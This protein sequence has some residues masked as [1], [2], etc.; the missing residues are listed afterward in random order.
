MTDKVEVIQEDREAAAAILIGLGLAS[1]RRIAN[2]RKG[3]W[4]DDGVVQECA[5][6]R[7]AA[8][9]R[10]FEAGA[11]AMQIAAIRRATCGGV[12]TRDLEQ[13]IADDIRAIN[14]ASLK[15]VG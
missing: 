14:P 7:L 4:D 10:A 12:G 3:G 15:E 13:I 2:L 8:E 6:H 5:R 9:A 11:R 1:P